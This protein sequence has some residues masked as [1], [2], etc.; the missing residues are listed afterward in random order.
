MTVET[1]NSLCCENRVRAEKNHSFIA[2]RKV[3]K[4]KGSC[5]G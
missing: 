4:E 2:P 3:V 5:V 1:Q